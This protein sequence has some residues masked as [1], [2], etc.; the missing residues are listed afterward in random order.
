MKTS[1]GFKNW[2]TL[3]KDI[4]ITKPSYSEILEESE[5]AQTPKFKQSE[6]EL[7]EAL[8]RRLKIGRSFLEKMTE[9]NF[10]E[11]SCSKR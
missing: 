10:E 4:Q 8:S 11:S 1:T 3:E 5:G 2:N 7:K 9:A 6:Q